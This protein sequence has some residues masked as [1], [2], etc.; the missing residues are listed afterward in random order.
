MTGAI[1]QTKEHLRMLDVTDKEYFRQQ[2]EA[3]DHNEALMKQ[4]KN[5]IRR[6]SA[7]Q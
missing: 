6:K 4:L 5:S 7:K 3:Q 1:E 2:K